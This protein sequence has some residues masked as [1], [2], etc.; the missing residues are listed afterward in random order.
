M[1]MTMALSVLIAE[2]AWA[3]ATQPAGAAGAATHPADSQLGQPD[4]ATVTAVKGTVSYA[5]ARA[6]GTLGE[7]V[8][9]KVGDS[10][11]PGTRIQTLLRSHVAITF[12]YDTVILI[13]AG[14]S[15]SIDDFRLSADT[16]SVKLGIAHGAIRGASAEFTLRSDLTIESPTATLSKRGTIGFRLEYEPI[17]GHFV[18]SLETEGLVEA[19]NKLTNEKRL[20]RPKE[21][22]T[23][24]MLRWIVTAIYDD[25]I[26]YA[27][28]HG[29]T[30]ADKHF[31]AFYANGIAAIEPSGG[32]NSRSEIGINP[33]PPFPRLD[34]RP[35]FRF[36]DG[37]APSSR[38]PEGNF[39]TGPGS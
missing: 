25:Y 12:T 31:G 9:A 10:L 14:T 3:Q 30:Q 20:I 21:Y 17:T 4:N 6:D 1:L 19:L 16:K 28:F 33:V 34:L 24:V 32:W 5:I 29:M 39:G 18:I 36:P 38:T 27:E 8:P 23:Q 11:P 35:I 15:A 26:P 2:S 37:G 7:W 22:V 13:E